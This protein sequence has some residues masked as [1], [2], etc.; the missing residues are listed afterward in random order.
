MNRLPNRGGLI[1]KDSSYSPQFTS[2]LLAVGYG[3]DGAV[4]C[5]SLVGPLYFCMESESN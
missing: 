5:R 4:I 1:I 3:H 2:S